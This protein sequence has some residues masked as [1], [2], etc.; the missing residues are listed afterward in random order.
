MPTFEMTTPDGKVY[1]VEGD[2]MEGALAALKQA[3]APRSASPV[4]DPALLAQLNAPDSKRRVTDPALLAK[5]NG[6]EPARAGNPFEEFRQKPT[7]PFAEFA[8]PSAAGGGDPIHIGAPDGSIVQFPAG[9]NDETI[10]AAMR[11]AYPPP[12]AEPKS[13]LQTIREAV[14]APT[15]LLENG[16]FL[17]LGDRARAVIDTALA[18][19]RSL[20]GLITGDDGSY[21]ANLKNEQAETEQ[22]QKDHPIAAPVLEGVGGAVAPIG[23]IA[24]ASKGVGLGAKMAYGAGAG[25]GIGGVQGALG[26]KDWTNLP[27]VGWDAGTGAVINGIVGGAIPVAGQAIGAGFNAAANAARGRVDGM[28]RAAGGHLIKAIEA[29]GPAAVRQRLTELGPDAMLA[30]AGPALLGKAQGASLNSDEGRSVLQG[31]LTTRNE[32]TN[33]RIMGDVN[34]ALG[35][36]EDPQTVTNFIKAHRTAVDNVNYP[37][38]LDNAPAVKTA[39]IMRDLFDRIDQ[40]PVGGM[41]HKAL[42]NLQKMLTKTEKEPMLDAGG[43]QVYDKHGNERFNDVPYSHDDANILHKVKGELDNIIEYDAPGLGVPAGALTRQQGALKQMRGAIND[44]LE[45]QVPGYANANR[46]SAAL[47]R[48][49]DAVELGT[50]YLGNGKTTASPERFA[51]AFDPLSLGEKIAFAKGSRG[52]VDRILGTK[53]NDLQALRGELQGEGGWNTAKIATVHGQA[54]ADELVSS[55]DRN[56]KFRDTHNKVVENSQTAQRNA[57]AKEMK[58]DP[59]T[60]TPLFNPNSTIAGMGVTA[61]KKSVQSIINAL[62][63]SDPTRHY[64]EVARALTEQG[65]ARDAR[66]TAIIDALDRRRGN[67]AVS[68]AAGDRTALLGAI[69]ANA[70]LRG[71][72]KRNQGQP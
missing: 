31:A 9:T 46:V 40:T 11:R 67:A 36:A 17:G 48:R 51:A 35:P 37:A 47:A 45:K 38:A 59:S 26:S 29:D 8:K 65:S 6:P 24:A 10:N 14:H 62:T 1:H 18:R 58:P 2:N 15:R 5:L 55:V 41:E 34:R 32:G 61:A 66:L 7:N 64:G 71:G 52:N 4:T 54:G 39:P 70:A 27:Q 16:V 72:P 50:Q 63:R 21:G 33:A 3:T 49:G 19:P 42:T 43:Y 22:F 12:A 69:A 25:F 56:L 28:S 57:A 53:A 44:A 13:T 30:D 68:G 60:D 23:A 20:S